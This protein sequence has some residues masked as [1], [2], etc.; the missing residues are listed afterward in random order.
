MTQ[1]TPPDVPGPLAPESGSP[2][3]DLQ[4]SRS[5]APLTAT[6]SR[7]A[8]RLAESRSDVTTPALVADQ[9][10]A[11]TWSDA[12]A[13][14]AAGT[15]QN[16]V[17]SYASAA[18]YIA[19]W[20][21]LRFGED[22]TLPV[23][24]SAAV[25]FVLDHLPGRLPSGE[26]TQPAL[27]A[28]IDRA[29]VAAGFKSTVG[30]LKPSTVNHRLSYLSRVHKASHLASPLDHTDVRSL[31]RAARSIAARS[32]RSAPRK[33]PALTR[34]HMHA[35]LQ[36]CD[37]SLTGKRDRALLLFGWA[38]GG[39]RRSEIAG[40]N[41]R[42]LRR[43]SLDAFD[44]V[45]DFSKTNQLGEIS[46]EDFKP[47]RG[48][49][50]QAMSAWLGASSIEEGPIFRRITSQ[51][52]VGAP[53]TDQAVSRI[54]TRLAERAGLDGHFT[55]HSLRSGFVTQAHIDQ[56]PAA[57]AMAMTGHASI[58]VYN[59]YYRSDPDRPRRSANLIDPPPG[60]TT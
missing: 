35:L 29:L 24:A 7:V 14:L 11:R 34:D 23:P 41:M 51:G 28:D 12:V 13:M 18:Q 40:A 56:V 52:G 4:P 25:R 59:S 19:G 58:T 20:F 16:T 37:Q 60:R 5:A 6:A 30:P 38:T 2:E 54:V 21:R 9:L 57:E 31:L 55:A 47:L 46:P 36:Q 48:A 42:N 49:A 15:P 17:R 32:P 22:I 44:Y 45:L 10:D 43:L 53:L 33:A 1:T 26:F 27:P 8:A 50:A 3:A 39:R